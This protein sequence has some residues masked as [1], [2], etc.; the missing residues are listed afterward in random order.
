MEKIFK[1]KE[2][3]TTI[4]TEIIAGLTTFLTMA[5]IIFLNPSV[6]GK[7]NPN[8]AHIPNTMEDTAVI[9]ATCIA[10]AIGTWLMGWLSNYPLALAP[11]LGLNAFFTYTVVLGMGCSWQLALT[12]VLLEGI[13]FIILSI[14]S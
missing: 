7:S 12:A 4:K 6:I 10:A 9:T 14:S 8:L 1:L 11:G 2:N 13:L 3:G 5:Y